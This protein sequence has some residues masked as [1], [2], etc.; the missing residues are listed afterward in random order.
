MSRTNLNNPKK[1]VL[2]T[3]IGRQ[4]TSLLYLGFFNLWNLLYLRHH[5]YFL[6]LTRTYG[7]VLSRWCQQRNYTHIYEPQL[8]MGTYNDVIILKE[9]IVLYWEACRKSWVIT[10]LFSN[11]WMEITNWT[12]AYTRSTHRVKFQ[13]LTIF[14]VSF[15]SNS[16]WRS[17]IITV[18]DPQSGGWF[19]K[20]D[21]ISKF[22][23][24]DSSRVAIC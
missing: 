8:E 7:M 14:L 17:R 13:S 19:D 15:L 9:S 4:M 12:S 3:V 16:G 20:I 1:T 2:V 6:N 21:Q 23:I 5:S 18:R 22:F 10:S 24:N 11:R